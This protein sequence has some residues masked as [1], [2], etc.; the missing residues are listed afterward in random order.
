MEVLHS[1][2]TA[3]LIHLDRNSLEDGRE[4]FSFILSSKH[5][6]NKTQKWVDTILKVS[7]YWGS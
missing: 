6:K 2:S 1:N 3:F 7:H 4:R 5:P